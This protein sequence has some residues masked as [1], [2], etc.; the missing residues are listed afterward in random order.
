LCEVNVY[1]KDLIISVPFI[2]LKGNL[3]AV[4]QPQTGEVSNTQS[5]EAQGRKDDDFDFM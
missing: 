5:E 4:E 2:K 3:S 1:G